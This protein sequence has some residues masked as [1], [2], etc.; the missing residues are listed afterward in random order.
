MKFSIFSVIKIYKLNIPINGA[1]HPVDKGE[2]GNGI[3]KSDFRSALE[4]QDDGIER[5][6][7]PEVR[8]QGNDEIVDAV[9]GVVCRQN[10]RLVLPV[11]LFGVSVGAVLA[12]LG[13]AAW[14]FERQKNYTERLEKQREGHSISS[15]QLPAPAADNTTA[16]SP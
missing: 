2:V 14:E 12:D 16:F 5:R 15:N 8:P 11:V 13:G 3:Q 9:G 6:L 7:L 10:H 4:Q 1:Q